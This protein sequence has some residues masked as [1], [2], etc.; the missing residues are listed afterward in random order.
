MVSKNWEPEESSNNWQNIGIMYQFVEDK[1]L[2]AIQV[3]VF[4]AMVRKS[5][6]YGKKD[7]TISN[8]QLCELVSAT[9]KTV[10]KAVNSLIK[11]GLIERV[12]WQDIGPKQTYRYQ[13][14]FPDKKY[15]FIKIGND[16]SGSK[17]DNL[18]EKANE[19]I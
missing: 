13:I 18:L 17:S 8:K 16:K 19:S 3:S 7:I 15:G 1:K 2:P 11:I 14:I 5:F 10:T 4:M 6:G 9:D 12:V